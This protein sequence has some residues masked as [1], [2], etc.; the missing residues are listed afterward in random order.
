M[1]WFIDTS[2]ARG[3]QRSPWKKKTFS[4]SKSKPY[5]CIQYHCLMKSEV[6]ILK[7]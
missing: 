5:D 1:Q 2:N 4:V 3:P 6:Q 7:Y